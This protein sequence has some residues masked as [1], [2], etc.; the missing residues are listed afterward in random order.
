MLAAGA[1]VASV[2]LWA[3]HD[4]RVMCDVYQHAI[5]GRG[6]EDGETIG[7]VFG[8]SDSARQLRDNRSAIRDVS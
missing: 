6:V 5:P 7:R 3:G 1:P 2:A 8:V 4:V